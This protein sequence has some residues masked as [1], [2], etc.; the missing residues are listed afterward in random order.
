MTAHLALIQH[1]HKLLA[2]STICAHAYAWTTSSQPW[3]KWESLRVPDCLLNAGTHL[4]QQGTGASAPTKIDDKAND[5]LEG[6]MEPRIKTDAARRPSSCCA[7]FLES[8]PPRMFRCRL[9]LPDV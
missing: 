5:V 1:H 7:L 8:H 3:N 6:S 9:L 2:H 4:H